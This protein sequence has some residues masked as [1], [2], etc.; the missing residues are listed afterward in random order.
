M[1]EAYTGRLRILV[2]ITLVWSCHLLSAQSPRFTGP[3]AVYH[4]SAGYTYTDSTGRDTLPIQSLYHFGEAA[5][6]NAHSDG[7]FLFSAQLDSCTAWHVNRVMGII[8]PPSEKG[9][10]NL[11]ADTSVFFRH[12]VHGSGMIQGGQRFS[13]LSRSYGPVCGVILDD[14]NGD[15]AI[16]RDVYHAVRGRYVDG[17]GNVYRESEEL[18]PDNRLYCVLYN[19][20]AHPEVMPYM[21]GLYYSYIDR[22][23]CC[24]TALDS[25]ID[26]LRLH[27]PGKEIMI[28]TFVSNS[29]LGWTDPASVRYMIT[30]GLD[31]YDDGDISQVCIFAGTLLPTSSMSPGRVDSF[32]LPAFLDSVYFPYLG[33]AAGH[34]YDCTSGAPL[35][36]ACIRVFSR[37]RISGDTLYRSRQMSDA[38]GS[39]IC[40]LWAGNR[41]TDSTLHWAIVHK[42]GYYPDTISFWVRR[43]DTTALPGIS[44]CSGYHSLPQG[45]FLIY[46]DPGRGGYN[47]HLDP[48]LT[49]DAMVE[50][51][52]MSGRR[53]YANGVVRDYMYIDLGGLQTGDYIVSLR[54]SGRVVR[55][56]R[57]ALHQ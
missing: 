15:T 34:V 30:R 52:D 14:W 39:F 27:F 6:Q 1:K 43:G 35:P 41:A 37:G 5:I 36:G 56:L 9:T 48:S 13:R 57:V 28:A 4:L 20:D 24:Y 10:Y 29:R 53:M 2:I 31:R 33:M 54:Q 8:N 12:P 42:D 49:S 50:V 26:L 40:G 11:P 18:T 32:A 25:D 22:Q 19:T 16:T 47:I 55:S 46:P 3:L 51:H 7:R 17:E 21:D 45:D 38:S 23:N 44:L